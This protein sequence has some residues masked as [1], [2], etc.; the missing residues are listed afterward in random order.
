MCRTHLKLIATSFL[1][2]LIIC[3]AISCKKDKD[4]QSKE[5]TSTIPKDIISFEF[6]SSDNS[7]LSTDYNT[8]FAGDAITGVLPLGTNL[9]ALKAD[10]T[11]SKNVVILVNG[12]VQTSRVTANDFRQPVVY[13]VKAEDGSTKNYTVTIT[14]R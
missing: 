7:N 9:S 12:Q 1:F 2:V 8:S 3:S 14:T 4:Q 13:T 10:F 5:Q 6:H 11:T